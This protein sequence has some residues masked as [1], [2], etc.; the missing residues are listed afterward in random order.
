M[1]INQSQRWLN[2]TKKN[3]KKDNTI[4]INSNKAF[5]KDLQDTLDAL[6]YV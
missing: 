1:V 2:Y 6:P 5:E 3:R 4:L